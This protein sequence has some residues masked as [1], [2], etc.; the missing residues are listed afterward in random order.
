MSVQY[1]SPE[2][3][4]IVNSWSTLP[5]GTRAVS[6]PKISKARLVSRLDDDVRERLET[7][8]QKQ[9]LSLNHIVNDGLREYAEWGS[10]YLNA[11]LA[12]VG[13]R[14]LR[15]L[16]D[17]LPEE[18]A[19]A[20]GRRNGRE[21][22]RPMVLSWYGAFN[23]QNVLRV[24]ERVLAKYGGTFV[25]EHSQEGRRHTAFV[26]HEM[27]PKASA[28]YAE[29]ARVICELLNMPATIAETDA[30]VVIKAEEPVAN[31]VQE[32]HKLVSGTA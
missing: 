29:Y 24:F 13:K 11:G 1:H 28:Y 3:G 9:N 21:E 14:M 26:R 7:I 2:N 31:A 8:S 15:E 27:G 19:R 10:V 25:F 30:Q 16:F 12:V 4:E 20:L 32:Q 23:L 18:K 6:M 5:I 17:N 22:A